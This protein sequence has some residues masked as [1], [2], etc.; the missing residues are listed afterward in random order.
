M[1]QE[2]IKSTVELPSTWW[3]RNYGISPPDPTTADPQAIVDYQLTVKRIILER[4]H[5]VPALVAACEDEHPA[6]CRII[7]LGAL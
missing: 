2:A 6:E 1:F 3:K 5:D 7:L 4:Y